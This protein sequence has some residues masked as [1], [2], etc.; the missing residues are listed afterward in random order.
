MD[1]GV[2]QEQLLCIIS[3]SVLFYFLT[4]VYIALIFKKGKS[5]TSDSGAQPRLITTLTVEKAQYQIGGLGS[6][7]TVI[8]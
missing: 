1:V 8:W 7:S 4:S 6:N 5:F 2:Q 3:P